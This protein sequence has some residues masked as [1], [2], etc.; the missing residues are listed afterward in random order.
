MW[1]TRWTVF[2]FPNSTEDVCMLLVYLAESYAASW[3][4]CWRMT[5]LFYQSQLFGVVITEKWA[6]PSVVGLEQFPLQTPFKVIISSCQAILS[7][8]E[9]D[10]G[11]VD[12]P[13]IS[14][15]VRAFTGVITYGQSHCRIVAF[16]HIIHYTITH[17]IM[18]E[19]NCTINCP[20]SECHFFHWC[21]KA[22]S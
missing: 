13:A 11:S 12:T 8:C 18:H 17:L 16:L 1:F 19:M 3:L 6:V 4:L 2:R 15:T 22:K 9:A 5:L 14:E 20:S 10:Q 21:R 7:R